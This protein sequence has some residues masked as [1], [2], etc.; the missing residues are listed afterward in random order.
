MARNF[1]TEGRFGNPLH[2][3][4]AEM[5]VLGAMLISER[6]CREVANLLIPEDFY[7]PAHGEIYQS[8]LNLMESRVAI[9]LVTAKEKLG[10]R[11]EWIGGI[12]YLVQIAEAVPAAS[13]AEFYAGIVLEK[14]NARRIIEN[15]KQSATLAR[16]GHY[17]EALLSAADS[18]KG[19]R[20]QYGEVD[21]SAGIRAASKGPPKA[22]PCFL[23]TVNEN[24]K[25][26]GFTMGETHAFCAE[27]GFGKTTFL[28]QQIAHACDLGIPTALVT[29]EM[30]WS[31]LAQKILQQMT[32]Y[33]SEEHA[34]RTSDDALKE[35]QSAMLR[36]ETWDLYV[37]D[38]SQDFRNGAKATEVFSWLARMAETKGVK[39]TIIDY[40]QRIQPDNPRNVG[41]EHH[42]D[43]SA[44]QVEFAKA[45]HVANLG[46]YQIRWINGKME[47]KGGDKYR[48]DSDVVLVKA[49]GKKD[50]QGHEPE[51][52]VFQKARYRKGSKRA[53]KIETFYNPRTETISE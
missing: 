8:F 27:S 42:H 9:D 41:H 26:G 49:V 16:T 19:V 34:A 46:L 39:H 11:L 29:L 40:V 13:N 35:Y 48:D 53:L 33:W 12:E 47:F 4:E 14:A 51:Y 24:N 37:F 3:V 38:K 28:C 20:A 25:S 18:L 5:S 43:V 1:M 2:S 22:V 6:S 10:G 17:K 31:K 7:T 52:V 30:E 21:V 45:Y 36:M 50:D 23:P 32:G 15:A 44:R